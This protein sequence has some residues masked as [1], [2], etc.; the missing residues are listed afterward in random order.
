[1][2]SVDSTV[3]LNFGVIRELTDDAQTALEQTTDQLLTQVKNTQ[4][5]PFEGGTLNN[6]GTFADCSN[7]HLGVTS[8]ISDTPYARRWY[9]NPETVNVRDYIIKKGKRAGQKVSGYT[10]GKAKFS[11]EKHIKATDHWFDDWL[12]GGIH[13]NFCVETFAKIYGRLI[14]S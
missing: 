3:K 10:A 8:I 1:M 12:P 5:M 9:Y 6:E 2:F 13:E 14:K 4:V 7:S 11:K